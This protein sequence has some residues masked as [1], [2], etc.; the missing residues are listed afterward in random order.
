MK[1]LITQKKADNQGYL[2]KNYS[3]QD[4]PARAFQYNITET[5]K[6]LITICG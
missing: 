1:A 4:C 6:A 5:M 2:N 3:R